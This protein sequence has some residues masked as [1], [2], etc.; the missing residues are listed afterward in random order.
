MRENG[1]RVMREER[2]GEGEGMRNSGWRVGEGE[3]GR[4]RRRGKK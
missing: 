1:R 4:G 2:K 3:V